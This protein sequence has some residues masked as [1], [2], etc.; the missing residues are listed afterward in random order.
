MAKFWERSYIPSVIFSFLGGVI[1]AYIVPQIVR[2][3]L[4][5][6]IFP[7]TRTELSRI[8]SSDGAIDAVLIK[9]ECGTPC[10]TSY[11]VYIVPN[12]RITPSDAKRAIFSAD[13]MVDARILWKQ[14]HL[15]EIAYEKALIY[16]FRNVSYPLGEAGD[17][18]G[19]RYGVEIRL[20]PNTQGF[21]YLKQASQ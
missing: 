15:L 18:G 8:T 9:S 11:S 16:S 13:D 4:N 20:A 19:W 17:E 6:A 1:S 10:S 21:S 7:S 2:M 5:R 3:V 14:P 12:G